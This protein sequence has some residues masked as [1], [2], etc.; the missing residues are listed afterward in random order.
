MT[1]AEELFADA[2]AVI[3]GGV[4]SPVRAF[5]SVGGTPVFAARGEDI[6]GHRMHSERYAIPQETLA[7]IEGKRVLA[8]GTTS[9]RALETHRLTGKREGES[10]LFITPG[11]K[12]PLGT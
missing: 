8:V 7:A 11:F 10:D 6:E 2:Q 9:L 1:T 4:D 12:M 5:G 3:P